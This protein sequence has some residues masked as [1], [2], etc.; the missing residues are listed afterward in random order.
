MATH[1]LTFTISLAQSHEE[2]LQACSVRS[3]SYGHHVP[4]WKRA[5]AQPD[6]IDLLPGTA[7]LLATDKRTGQAVGTARIQVTSRGESGLCIEQCVE[8]P[9]E[10]KQ[11]A[12][13]EITRLSSLPGADPLV[14]LALWKAGYLYC[15]A[16]QARWLLIGARSEALVRSYR[17]LGTRELYE[18]QRMV[19]LTYAGGVPH[20]VLVFDVIAAER[21]WHAAN[22][23]L[24]QFMFETVHP[25][26]QLFAQRSLAPQVRTPAPQPA[27]ETAWQTEEE[28]AM[29]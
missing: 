25:D 24:F 4:E 12:R 29:A 17:R 18:D 6:A 26:I 15:H 10:M 3:D 11:D 1:Q 21:N 20:R 9:Q 2:L 23:A 22:H 28:E 27:L 14:R 8:L 13:A 16:N 5:Y 7:V 19:P